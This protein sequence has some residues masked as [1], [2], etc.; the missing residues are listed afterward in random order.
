MK[1]SSFEENSL[2]SVI[3]RSLKNET[4]YPSTLKAIWLRESNLLFLKTIIITI[5]CSENMHSLTFRKELKK[6]RIM[7]F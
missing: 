5:L 3:D 7:I 4:S 1:L 2:I 6:V